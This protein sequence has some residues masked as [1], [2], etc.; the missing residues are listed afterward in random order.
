MV[1][2]GSKKATEDKID[3]KKEVESSLRKFS[4]AELSKSS[5]FGSI[6][7]VVATNIDSVSEK[8]FLRD[9]R[10]FLDK[11]WSYYSELFDTQMDLANSQ[12]GMQQ[13]M[14]ESGSKSHA[15]K[16]QSV[17]DDSYN[18]VLKTNAT[19]D[20]LSNVIKALDKKLSSNTI[21]ST[22]FAYYKADFYLVVTNKNNVQQK[23]DNLHMMLT[24][25]F[26]NIDPRTIK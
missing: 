11:Q 17:V 5:D 6:D 10:A 15:K 19:M 18:D 20:S 12:I 4:T 26:K 7:S 8:E 3:V 22:N 23:V 21:D 9:H 14:I 1:S 2:C 16:Y 13:L 25:D 24:K